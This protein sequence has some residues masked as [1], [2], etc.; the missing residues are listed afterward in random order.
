M[1]P[2][3][4]HNAHIWAWKLT[5]PHGEKNTHT[6]GFAPHSSPSFNDRV[7]PG[8]K[9]DACAVQPQA[10]PLR[11]HVIGIVGT[12]ADRQTTPQVPRIHRSLCPTRPT[13][14]AQTLK[15]SPRPL[16]SPSVHKKHTLYGGQHHCIGFNESREWPKLHTGRMWRPSGVTPLTLIGK[17]KK[18]CLLHGYWSHV[19]RMWPWNIMV[20]SCEWPRFE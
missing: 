19:M 6:Q 5:W 1:W 4:R 20:E 18:G 14:H 13:A 16:A 17:H 3:W 2:H 10:F 15:R 9:R 12:C 11:S 8:N 7:E